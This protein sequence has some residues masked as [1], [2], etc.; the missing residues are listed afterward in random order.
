MPLSNDEQTAQ[1]LQARRDVL[2]YLKPFQRKTVEHVD[3]LYRSGARR[4][5]VA[6][7]VGLGKTLV[8]KGVVATTAA[9]RKEENDPFFKVVYVCSNSAIVNQNLSK[10]SVDE[11]LVD[12]VDA[13]NAR[14]SMQHFTSYQNER[15]ARD[16]NSYIQL[17]PL[18]PGTSFNVSNG[19]GAVRERALIFA[20]LRRF[21]LF[22]D[23]TRKLENMFMAPAPSSWR[24]WRDYYE[25]EVTNEPGYIDKM[26]ESLEAY[27]G[28]LREVADYLVNRK[29]TSDD[30]RWIG[31]IRRDFALLSVEHLD[32]D[33]V[34]MDEFQRFR[35]LLDTESDT[36][37]SIIAKKF[38]FSETRKDD[39][40]RI[41][42]LSATPFKPF[43]TSAEDETFFGDSAADDFLNLVSFLSKSSASQQDGFF[44]DIWKEYG[45]VLSQY[46]ENLSD[47]AAVRIAKDNA[48][49][50]LRRLI[51]RTERDG[52]G[53]YADIMKDCTANEHIMPET[54]D[55]SA[56]LTVRRLFKRMGLDQ[57][58]P[59]EYAESCPYLLSYLKGYKLGDKL[60]KAVEKNIDVL[61]FKQ[62]NH[63]NARL[64]WIQSSR[65]ARFE[66]LNI[67]NTRFERLMEDVFETGNNDFDAS[68][69]LW[70]PASRPYYTV[71][72]GPFAGVK[73]FSKTLIFSSWTMV[74]RMAS[75]LLSYEDERRSVAF[76]YE[77]GH[78][79]SYFDKDDVLEAEDVDVRDDDAK[80]LPSKRLNIYRDAGK[81]PAL[82]LYPSVALASMVTW[83]EY[84]EDATLDS[85]VKELAEQIREK[86][87]KIIGPQRIDQLSGSDDLRWFL[88]ATLLL[89]QDAGLP[90]D[91]F[92][93][94]IKHDESLSAPER[95]LADSWRAM[96]ERSVNELG[97]IPEKLY[98][99]LAKVALG[100]PAVCS[101]RMF[102]ACAEHKT[103]TQL[104][105][106]RFSTALLRKLNTPSATL[107][108]ESGFKPGLKE[109]FY[110]NGAGHYRLDVSDD[111]VTM[112]FYPGAA[113]EPAR[114]FNL[115]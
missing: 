5:L 96:T 79:Y 20:V 2:A 100:S 78:S 15:I 17:I 57:T 19:Q 110:N 62:E 99:T 37:L 26:L 46:V 61:P 14:L 28:S 39:P 63:K 9:L 42:L 52:M 7:E 32:P 85:M 59:V 12:R 56:Q 31:R 27:S 92:L 83:P 25:R 16:N 43:S 54:S 115:A 47:I 21:R 112:A 89:E 84:A 108:V 38:L 50:S 60:L 4:V 36:D 1:V 87:E 97:K 10:L 44:K 113:R 90:V 18:T 102:N 34:I 81:G 49:H 6:D 66:K 51:A 8:A 91:E 107:A 77:K 106:Y 35:D 22:R 29:D 64:L 40:V 109:Y 58:A 80:K 98:T 13:S 30:R 67:P 73:H 53:E 82:L 71:K 74:P 48:E 103:S 86:L 76:A 70:I 69:L 3:G 23:L 41:L 68:S 24:G 105:A 104:L 75:T 11:D 72:K 33:L 55:I 101:M 95:R 114:T 94:L 111:A 45:I 93:T 88:K 65:I